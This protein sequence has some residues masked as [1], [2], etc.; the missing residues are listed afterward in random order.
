[1]SSELEEVFD[2]MLVGRVP[3]MWAAKSYP[4]LKP[5]GSYITDLCARLAFFKEWIFSGTPT[6][7]WLSGFYFTQSF[8]TGVSQNYAR[9]YKVPIDRLNMDFEVTKEENNIS[10]KPV[11]I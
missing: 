7:F 5:L 9:K 1:M 2:K 10:K 3:S 8:L 6:V 11:R 4:S